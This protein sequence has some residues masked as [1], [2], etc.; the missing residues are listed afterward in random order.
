MSCT[1]CIHLRRIPGNCHMRCEN[2]P[3]HV[4]HIGGCG[5][6]LQ[7]TDAR[8]APNFA[9]SGERQAFADKMAGKGDCVVRCLWPGCGMFPFCFDDG[10]IFACSR[11]S[12]EEPMTSERKGC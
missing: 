10:G 2:P 8:G 5:P 6:G 4:I 9:N 3:N 11:Y 12:K 1:G 7:V